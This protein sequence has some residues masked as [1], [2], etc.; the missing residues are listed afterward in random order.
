MNAK[1]Q[2]TAPAWVDPDDAPE[3]T[4]AFFEQ[5][6]WRI[7]EQVVTREAAQTVL[8]RLPRGRPVGSTQA[9]IKRPTTLRL[10]ETTLARWRSS[11]K[12]WQTRAA[13]LLAAHAPK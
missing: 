1:L 12:G 7:G 8:A 6:V 10:D 2:N 4:D 11:G 3:L 13:E 9:T 5:A